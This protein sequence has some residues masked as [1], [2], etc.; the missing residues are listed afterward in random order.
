M[1]HTLPTTLP[2]LRAHVAVL[3]RDYVQWC[4]GLRPDLPGNFDFTVRQ[5][6]WRLQQMEQEAQR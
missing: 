5:A 3:L 6:K 4:Q 2:A 1:T